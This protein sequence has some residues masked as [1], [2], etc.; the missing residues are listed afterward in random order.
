MG[1]APG[2]DSERVDAGDAALPQGGRYLPEE[3]EPEKLP[4]M[5]DGHYSQ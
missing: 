5:V 3:E 1:S 2:I 4:D